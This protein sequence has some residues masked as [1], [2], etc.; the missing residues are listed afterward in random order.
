MTILIVEADDTERHLL[1]DLCAQVG[2]GAIG[3]RESRAAL[4]YLQ[5]TTEL[6]WVILL[7][8]RIALNDGVIYA[9][10]QRD[11]T[12]AA[13][14]IMIMADGQDIAAQA[15]RLGVGAYLTKPFEGNPIEAIVRCYALASRSRVRGGIRDDPGGGR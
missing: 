3:V 11:P 13:I 1:L 5:K 10:I 2:C 14:P 15:A 4:D 6:P 7:D 9:I 8:L 12:L